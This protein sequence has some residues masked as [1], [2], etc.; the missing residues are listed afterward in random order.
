MKRTKTDHFVDKVL[1]RELFSLMAAP[2]L[3]GILYFNFSAE[4]RKT[5][6]LNA[7][8]MGECLLKSVQQNG[9]LNIFISLQFLLKG[10]LYSA[11]SLVAWFACL[12]NYADII[13]ETVTL[14]FKIFSFSLIFGLQKC[15]LNSLSF[16]SL[17][18]KFNPDHMSLFAM[19]WSFFA[20]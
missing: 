11:L 4:S 20:N 16:Q 8:R 18:N 6:N 5:L 14:I 3:K 10:L 17:T 12:F 7:L 13:L 15:W 9:N 2:W 1:G 19:I